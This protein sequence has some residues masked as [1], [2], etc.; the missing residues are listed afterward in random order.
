[1]VF[2]YIIKTVIPHLFPA[3]TVALSKQS[4]D[5]EVTWN[6]STCAVACITLISQTIED[7]FIPI[8]LPFVQ[9]NLKSPDWRAREA[10]TIILGSVLEFC[11]ADS[12]AEILK[13]VRFIFYFVH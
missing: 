12:T 2:H 4:E 5:A 7:D 13:S 8:L 6:V 1:M 3:L 10:A 9:A 11:Q